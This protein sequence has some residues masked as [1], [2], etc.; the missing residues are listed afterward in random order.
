[1]NFT[2]YFQFLQAWMRS[3]DVYINTNFGTKGSEKERAMV[4][5]NLYST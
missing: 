3:T 2:I 1:M 5:I 4:P